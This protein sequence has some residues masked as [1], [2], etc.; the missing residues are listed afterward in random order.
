[1][2]VPATRVHSTEKK[3]VGKSIRRVEDPKLLAGRGGYIDD[4][5]LPGMLHATLVLSP[6]AHAKIKSVDVEAARRLPGVVAVVTGAEAAELCDPLPDF[7][8][9]PDKHVWRCLAVDKVRYVG[10]GVAEI[11]AASR[12]PAE[13][14]RDMVEVE[15]EPL[16]A[17]VDPEA[18][19]TPDAPVLHE[20]LGSNLAYERTF[21]FGEVDHDIA[22][23]DLVVRDRL[24]WHRSGAQPLETVGAIASYDAGTGMM[25]IH[26]NSLTFT[27][28][29]FLLAN[30]LKVPSN[31]LDIYPVNAGGSFGSKFW[32]VK[33]GVIAAML[34]KHVGFPVKFVEDRVDNISNCDHHGSD[35]VYDVEL[36]V[37]KDGTFRG[38]RLDTVDDYGAYIQFGTGTHGNSLAQVV[39]PYRTPCVQY[40][41]H[42]VLTNTRQQGP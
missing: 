11:V 26:I 19:L 13:D 38:L 28:Y 23:A 40:A 31:K 42:E 37:M 22:E 6:F 7:G 33:V 4:M 29:L 27:S 14:A 9:A 12:Y 41:L 30:T 21:V 5:D 8:P 36:A 17:V 34:A 15:Y 39:G 2:A 32:A 10:E 16:P 20:P 35:R 1:M 25:T 18:A 24:R 3:W